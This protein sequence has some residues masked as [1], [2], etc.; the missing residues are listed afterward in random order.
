MPEQCSVCGQKTEVEPG[1]Y[2]GTG[3]VSYALSLAFTGFSFIVWWF[4]IGFSISD[5]RLF[6]WLGA[7]AIL[8][9]LMQPWLMRTSRMLWLSWFF[10][11]DNERLSRQGQI[12]Q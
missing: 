6:W 12:K 3:Y 10:H 11:K 4:A 1:F 9:I 8:L 2:Y 7:N 5:N